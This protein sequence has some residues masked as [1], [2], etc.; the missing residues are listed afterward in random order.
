MHAEVMNWKMNNKLERV[1]ERAIN[2]LLAPNTFLGETGSTKPP[3]SKNTVVG[4]M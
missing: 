3:T 4:S 2:L 1:C